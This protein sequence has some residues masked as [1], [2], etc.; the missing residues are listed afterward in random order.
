[1]SIVALNAP[2]TYTR[3]I[4]DHSSRYP[5]HFTLVPVKVSVARAFVSIE[6]AHEPPLQG[7]VVFV[8]QAPPV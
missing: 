6:K 8:Y 1:M 5:I 2:S 7:A 3:A 4:P